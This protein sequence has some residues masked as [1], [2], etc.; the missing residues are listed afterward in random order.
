MSPTPECILNEHIRLNS[1]GVILS[2]SFKGD[3]VEK[4]REKFEKELS[5]SI[6]ALR[7]Y[8]KIARKMDNRQLLKSYKLMETNILK[9]AK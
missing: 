4:K 9:D 3:F 6:K 8:E 2:R 5:E 7:S 1:S